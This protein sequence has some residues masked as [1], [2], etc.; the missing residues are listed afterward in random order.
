MRDTFLKVDY[1]LFRCFCERILWQQ[2]HLAGSAFEAQITAKR[3]GSSAE[4]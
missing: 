2:L 3:F 4:N 1:Y